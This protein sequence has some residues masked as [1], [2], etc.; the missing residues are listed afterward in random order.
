MIG[1]LVYLGVRRLGDSGV[2]LLVRARCHEA[3]RPRVT[4]AVNRKVYMMFKRNGIEV[5]FPQLTIHTGDDQ[6]NPKE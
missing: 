3:F 2:A 1:D 6:N 5:P 4:R